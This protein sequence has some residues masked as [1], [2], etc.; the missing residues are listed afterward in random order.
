M[1]KIK[2][3][4]QPMW[5]CKYSGKGGLTLEE[6]QAAE[7]KALTALK[8]V[9]R[10]AMLLALQPP[11]AFDRCLPLPAV[12]V[13]VAL[14]LECCRSGWP[15]QFPKELEEQVCRAVHHSLLRVDELVGGIYDSLRPAAA[16][17]EP[18]AA[19]TGAA[20]GEQQAVVQQ[21]SPSPFGSKE[22]EPQ[23]GAPAVA[24][25]EKPAA[26]AGEPAEGGAEPE[27]VAGPEPATAKK[28]EGGAAAGEAAKSGKKPKT[29]KAP[30]SRPALRTYI[31]EVCRWLYGNAW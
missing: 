18:A 23:Q 21:D 7:H 27:A 19:A 4:D 5:S 8:A 28:P 12:A 9:S 11:R 16:A 17:E 6:A 26:P 2:L 22:N 30:V 24:A 3:Y 25:A 31:I 15:L 14:T 1:Q 20:D 29:P 10:A 13:L